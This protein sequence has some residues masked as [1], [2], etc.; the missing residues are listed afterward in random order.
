MSRGLSWLSTLALLVGSTVGCGLDVQGQAGTNPPPAGD[1][2]VSSAA[3]S[4]AAAGN[5][6]ARDAANGDAVAPDAAVADAG[7]ADTLA[8]EACVPTTCTAQ[9]YSCGTAPDGCGGTLSCGQCTGFDTCGG[10]GLMNVCGC[11]PSQCGDED[12][13]LVPDGCGGQNYC[14]SGCS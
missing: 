3:S 9:K 4:D 8:P 14:T 6:D 12:C 10:G 5:E 2:G 1:G 7:A 11:T 13:G